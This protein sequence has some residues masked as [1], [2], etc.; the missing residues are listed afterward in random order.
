[1]ES[2]DALNTNSLTIL[3]SF[4]DIKPDNILVDYDESTEGQLLVKTVQISDLEGTVLLQPGKK[5]LV[6]PLCGNAIWRSPESWCRSRQNK[7]S[8]IF[9]FGIVII[10]VMLNEMVFRVSDSQLTAPDSWRYILPRHV[11]YFADEQGLSGFL[12]HIGKDNPFHERLISIASNFTSDT[13]RQPF[14]CWE[15][16]DPD[17]RDL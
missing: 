8:D 15:H 12:E 10:Y 13:S 11:S 5:W 17:L 3:T 14:G 2:L 6:G 4:T 7:A 9:S 16:V 1:M